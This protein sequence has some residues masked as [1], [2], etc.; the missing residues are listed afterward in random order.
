MFVKKVQERNPQ[1]LKAALNFHQRGEILPDA[2][3][4]DMDT[5]L[6]NAKKMLD[7]AKKHKMSLYFMLKQ[8]G[9]NPQIAKELMNLGYEGA[10]VVDFKEAQVMMEHQI[11]ICNVGHLVQPPKHFVKKLV[12]YGCEYFTVYSL[13]KIRQIQS[14]AK[15]AGKT[16]KLMLRVIGNEDLIYS[17]QKAGFKLEEIPNLLKEIQQ[18]DHVEV[19][20]ITAFPCFLYNEELDENE[21]TNN[22]KT[23]LAAVKLC[24]E[25]GVNIDN[26]N[27]PSAT[28]IATLQ[29]MAKFRATSGEPGH[30]LTGTT[31]LHMNT[32]SYEKPCVLYLSEIS[33]TFD[34]KSYCFGGG[35]YRRSHMENA[36]VSQ[37]MK[38][39]KVEPPAMD[40]IDYHFELD[41]LFQVG[42]PV[43][44]AFRFQIFVTRSDVILLRGVSTKNPIIEGRYNSMGDEI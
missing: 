19:K 3:L 24:E 25:T 18:M 43:I 16:Q 23:V 27:T 6:D 12:E 44:L 37:E 21:P 13:D 14:C 30:G 5:L 1:L 17:G 28:C 10:V 29:K 4:I 40:S 2:Y 42:D 26:I 35:H 7:E 8:L 11:P 39:C 31:P 41:Q 9:R 15:Q 20:G 32:S 33:H 22:L 36:L 34:K 38:R